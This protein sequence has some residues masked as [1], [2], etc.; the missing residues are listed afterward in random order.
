VVSNW[1][2]PGLLG[3]GKACCFTL[4]EEWL[5]ML[6]FQCRVNKEVYQKS[7]NQ[8]AVQGFCTKFDI[9]HKFNGNNE[10]KIEILTKKKKGTMKT[11]F[12]DKIIK[13]PKNK[14]V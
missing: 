14:A 7:L 5:V 3:I 4:C 9:Y 1:L 6:E 13:V 12:S 10:E 2:R 11:K 8:F